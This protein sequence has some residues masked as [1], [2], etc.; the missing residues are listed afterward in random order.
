VGSTTL[1]QLRELSSQQLRT[2]FDFVSDEDLDLVER[3][4][5]ILADATPYPPGSPSRTLT[6]TRGS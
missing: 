2:L 6:E 5:R 3:A 4:L 1:G